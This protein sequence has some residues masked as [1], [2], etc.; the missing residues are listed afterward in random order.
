MSKCI[1]CGK[2]KLQSLQKDFCGR[3]CR[4]VYYN[5]KYKSKQ[6]ELD[7]FSVSM[8][9]IEG[10]VHDFEQV[11]RIN[12]MFSSLSENKIQEIEDIISKTVEDVQ[13]I[14]RD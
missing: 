10:T 4:D 7:I 1:Q 8:K 9:E 13:R 12:P 2:K 11:L 14:L 3:I 6:E 5:N